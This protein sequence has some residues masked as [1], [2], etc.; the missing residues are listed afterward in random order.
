MVLYTYLKNQP[1]FNNKSTKWIGFFFCQENDY[2]TIDLNINGARWKKLI[3]LAGSDN[4][5]EGRGPYL[6]L[7]TIS[8]HSR[9][10]RNL[11]AVLQIFSIAAHV[12]T[13]LLLDKIYQHLMLDFALKLIWFPC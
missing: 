8:T 9:T 5:W 11:F 10:F 4:S 13:R 1:Y 2:K 3:L 12:V 6:L 7:S